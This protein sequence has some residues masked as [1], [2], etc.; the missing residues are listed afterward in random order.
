[1]TEHYDAP[2]NS[3]G[4][5]RLAVA[6]CRE[7]GVRA[8]KFAPSTDDERRQAVEGPRGNAELDAVRCA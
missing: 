5:W 2:R 4:S 6:C 8:G 1:M 3:L 7:I